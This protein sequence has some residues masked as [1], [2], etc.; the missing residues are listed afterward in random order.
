MHMIQYLITNKSGEIEII[1]DELENANHKRA[2]SLVKYFLWHYSFW[3]SHLQKFYHSTKDNKFSPIC[4]VLY[5]Q[6]NLRVLEN[7][8]TILFFVLEKILQV[9]IEIQH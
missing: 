1:K 8:D 7:S 3:I 5:K 6:R 9:F 4:R 2:K